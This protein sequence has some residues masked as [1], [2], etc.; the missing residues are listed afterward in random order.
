MGLTQRLAMIAGGRPDVFE[1][2]PG[3]RIRYAAMGGVILSTAGVAAASA[4]MAVHMAMGL[5]VAVAL[6]VGLIWGF[7]IFN[8]DRLLVVQMMR[9]QSKWMSVLAAVPRLLLALVLGAVI[10]T[11]VVLQIFQPE[12]ETELLV[13]QA[14]QND[15]YNRQIA[16][17]P[18]YAQMP[19][20]AKQI[21]DDQATL[22]AGGAVNVEAD[23]AVV[24]ARK[25]FTSAQTA[26]NKAEAAVVCEKEGT[27]GSGKAG[28]G[29]A[30][31]EKVEIRDRLKG[32][33]DDAR[34]DLANAQTAAQA[35]LNEAQNTA[36]A[37]A[38]SRLAANQKTLADLTQRFDADKRAHE[39]Q[40]KNDDGL[41]ARLEALERLSDDRS[42]LQLAHIT[43]FL[44]FLALELLPVLMKLLQVLGP[45][46]AYDKRAK[47]VD[48]QHE[49]TAKDRWDVEHQ[50]E[51]KRLELVKDAATESN[52]KVVEA[53]SQVML[54]VLDAWEQYALAQS[55]QDV[56][57]WQNQLGTGAT[58]P[59]TTDDEG[60]DDEDDVT[61]VQ[62]IAPR[63]SSYPPTS[64]QVRPH[65]TPYQPTP[66][67]STIYQPA[68][69]DSNGYWTSPDDDN[70][71][72]VPIND[73]NGRTIRGT[74]T[75]TDP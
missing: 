7:I 66:P 41:L 37:T 25:T 54:K 70:E 6:L 20:L 58:S 10:S 68:P 46:T 4:T 74:A 38:T 50:I 33:M 67:T 40:S 64:S 55:E 52:Q 28:A 16:A 12:I 24:A 44:L 15:A 60:E 22:A 14:E 71:P 62:P 45:E 36:K 5:P 29:I 72:T 34:E 18:D 59:V 49:Q 65:V 11:P 21:T 3:D 57:R 27:C 35:S 8:L 13:L 26:Y 53:Q 39:A 31:N 56:R 75:V 19:L 9:Q 2:A 43:L 42:T 23:A 47:D 30:F 17:N 69:R 51:L 61:A 63:T 32:E 73:Y 48:A 1:A